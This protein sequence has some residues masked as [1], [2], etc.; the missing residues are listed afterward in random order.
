MTTEAELHRLIQRSAADPMQEPQFLRALLTAT[1]YVHM[2]LKRAGQKLHLVC[3]TRPDGLTVIPIFSDRGKA[4]GAARGAVRVGAVRGWELFMSAPGAS[5]M[6]DPNDTSTTLYPEE[7]AALLADGSAAIAP[8]SMPDAPVS[9]S[10]A[11][12]EDA[13]LA[14]LVVEALQPIDGVEAVHLVHAHAADSLDPT[15]L[16]AVVAVPTPLTERAARALALALQAS[17]RTPRLAVDMT[18]YE[19]DSPPEWVTLEGLGPVWARRP[20]VSH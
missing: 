9:V 11:L 13:W 10:P 5:F 18:S 4:T 3:F 12:P 14:D 15:G 16:L 7:I 2:P 8:T 19:P 17:T 6:L 1:L 20:R